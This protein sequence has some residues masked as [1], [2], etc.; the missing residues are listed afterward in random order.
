MMSLLFD[1]HVNYHSDSR[2]GTDL[3]FSIFS[4]TQQGL[5]HKKSSIGNQDSATLYLGRN[6][7]I[8]C[9]ADGCTGGNSLDRKSFNQVGAVV[10]GYLTVRLLRKLVLKNH[11]AVSELLP[12]FEKELMFHLRKLQRAVNPWR[13]ERDEVLRNLFLSTLIF[14]VITKDEYMIANC[15]D[16]D[17]V[18]NG[19]HSNLGKEGGSYFASNLIGIQNMKRVASPEE[20]NIRFHCISQGRSEDVR[21]MFIATDGFLD[22]DI[23]QQNEFQRFF[24]STDISGN[25]N[26]FQDRRSEFRKDFLPPTLAVKNGRLWPQDDATFISIRRVSKLDL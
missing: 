8:G 14:F 18:V 25:R 17:V 23:L 22:G 10:G 16:G 12:V 19:I 6:I 7:L 24:L 21:S 9:V 11:V 2:N 15:G 20:F 4:M 3:P 26:G 5:E 1:Y 13:F